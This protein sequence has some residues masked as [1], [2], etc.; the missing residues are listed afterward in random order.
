MRE[1]EARTE[2]IKLY[3]ED[4]FTERDFTGGLT[5]YYVG[6]LPK[7]PGPYTG[8]MGFSWEEALYHARRN[9]KV[10]GV[11]QEDVDDAEN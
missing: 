9:Q 5:R 4:S 6:Q 2:T 10:A 11:R 3:G 1:H 8:F 7:T